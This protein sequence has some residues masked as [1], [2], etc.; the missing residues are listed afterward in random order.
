MSISHVKLP[1]NA[2]QMNH[3]AELLTRSQQEYYARNSDIYTAIWGQEIHTG[4]FNEGAIQLS[5]ATR[6]MTLHV[7]ELAKVQKGSRILNF[8]CGTAMADCIVSLQYGSEH[9]SV[10]FSDAQLK[11]ARQNVEAMKVGGLVN[12]VQGDFHD[13]LVEPCS[14]DIVW[15]QQSLFHARDK[16]LTISNAFDA[17]VSGGL[18]VIEDTVCVNERNAPTVEGNFGKRTRSHEI[19]APSTYLRVFDDIGFR[20]I[21]AEDHSKDLENT[22]HAVI[23]NIELQKKV[24]ADVEPHIGWNKLQC[25]FKQSLDL[26]EDRQMTS[27]LFLVSKE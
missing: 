26:V 11:K 18:L 19:Y 6:N 2:K 9:L 24:L 21:Y 15:A 8:G 16:H 23:K 4:R 10:D 13:R 3:H 27:M 17:L 12:L 25:G 14:V 22:Y 20:L 7:A 1:K 5:D